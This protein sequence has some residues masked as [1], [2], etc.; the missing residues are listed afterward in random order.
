M[1]PVKKSLSLEEELQFQLRNMRPPQQSMPPVKKCLFRKALGPPIHQPPQSPSS[2]EPSGK[3]TK[4]GSDG[5][6]SLQ[7]LCQ[8]QRT[9]RK[10][11]RLKYIALLLNNL[12]LPVINMMSA[13]S[14]QKVITVMNQV[15]MFSF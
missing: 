13:L 14:S 2:P 4:S 15:M 3:E 9:V 6:K 11:Q 10:T 12:I 7:Q 1:P 8:Q 5:D